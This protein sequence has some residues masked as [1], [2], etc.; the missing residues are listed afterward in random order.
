M[1]FRPSC[2][3]LLVILLAGGCATQPIRPQAPVDLPEQIA[4]LS[5]INQWQVQ[6]KMA[7][8][9]QNEA[10]SAN[11]NW[12]VDNSDFHFRLTNFLGVTLVDMTN[13]DGVATLEADD[14]VY[15]ESDPSWLVYQVTGWH[16][17]LSPLLMWVKGVPLATD[18]YTLNESGLLASL[19][20]GC[21][22][23]GAWQITYDDYRETGGYWLPHA[24]TLT[25]PLQPTNF[26]KIRIRT[27]TLQT[28]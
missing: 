25:Q 15:Q 5:Q 24:I 9:D 8:R 17:P 21:N 14:E 13:Q 4:Q 19:T 6:G 2:A 7:I 20:P 3:L 28:I 16:I 22:R 27:W 26:I 10:V 23:C 1:R 12:Q 18:Q 11:L